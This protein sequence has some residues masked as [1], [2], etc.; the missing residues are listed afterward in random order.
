[1]SNI[2]SPSKFSIRLRATNDELWNEILN[3]L[4]EEDRREADKLSSFFDEPYFGC[5]EITVRRRDKS[6]IA[7]ASLSE[8]S[9]NEEEW[10]VYGE[11]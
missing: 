5:K 11:I 9:E 6:Q 7:F 4:S 2:N 8:I 1:M 10:A 3:T